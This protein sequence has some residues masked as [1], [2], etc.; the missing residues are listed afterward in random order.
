VSSNVAQGL[1]YLHSRHIAHRDLKPQNIL[2][3]FKRDVLKI[4]DFGMAIDVRTKPKNAV[5]LAAH[6][7]VLNVLTPKTVLYFGIPRT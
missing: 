7:S 1:T 3:N 4:A 6:T 5:S 2:I